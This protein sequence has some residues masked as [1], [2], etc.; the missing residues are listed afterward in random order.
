MAE[1]ETTKENAKR[2]AVSE[3]VKEAIATLS[4]GGKV[5][6]AEKCGIS[7]QAI[8]GW[9]KT[10]RI[11][12]AN[13]AV[14]AEMTNYSLEWLITGKGEKFRDGSLPSIGKNTNAVWIDVLLAWENATSL[15]ENEVEPGHLPAGDL[16][17]SAKFRISKATLEKLGIAPESAYCVK[18]LGN[19]M[20]PLLPNAS[21]VA[22]NIAKRDVIDGKTYVIDHN[23]EL[24]VKLLYKIQGGGIAVKSYNS[25]EFPDEFYIDDKDV[26][27]IGQV[28]WSSV[29]W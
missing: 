21:T 15:N 16:P 8:T 27:V 19:S 1:I 23:G 22:I 11:D 2:M 7:S 26:K 17:E 28:F 18:V 3:R 9:E 25:T 10:G 20:D 29:V 4:R 13:I 6:I 12:K 14:I 5:R 24:R